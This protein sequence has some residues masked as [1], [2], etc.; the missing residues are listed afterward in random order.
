MKDVQYLIYTIKPVAAAAP[1]AEGEAPAQPAVEAIQAAFK[2]GVESKTVKRILLASSY[3]A[4]TGQ[5]RTSNTNTLLIAH[6][7]HF[8]YFPH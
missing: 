7:P 1:A 3:Q 4:I 6:F 8:L 5:R 2:A